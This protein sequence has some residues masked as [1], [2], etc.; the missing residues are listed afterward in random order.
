MDA[1]P[2]IKHIE[3]RILEA[4]L[5]KARERFLIINA[6]PQT[7]KSSYVGALLPFWL[8]G[9]MP[10]L[11][12]MY[13]SY[14]DDFSES[15]SKDVRA[16]QK[17]W[18]KELFGTSIDPDH[19]KVAEWRILGHR[20]GMLSVGIGGLITGKPG[21]C[22]P[23]DTLVSTPQGPRRMDWLARNGGTVWGYDH[24]AGTAVPR[25]IVASAAKGKRPLVEVI[26]TS[27][28]R[29]RC[30]A[31]HPIYVVGKGYTPAR[32]VEGG[33]EVRAH[34]V[35]PCSQCGTPVPMRGYE[36][37][38]KMRT[39]SQAIFC[40]KPCFATSMRS[41]ACVR[42]GALALRGRKFCSRACQ[43]AANAESLPTATCPTCAAT[44]RPR[45]SRQRFC[46]RGCANIAHS[47][48]MIGA[49]NSHFK[50]GTSY[51][52]LF[53]EMRP[54]V[55]GRDG[56]SCV[57]CQSTV[58]LV[59]H[60]VDHNPLNNDPTNLIALCNSCHMRHHKS[61]PTPFPWFAQYAAAA[62]R[63]MTSRWRARTT[64]LQAKFSSTTAFS[65]T[66]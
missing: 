21:D 10:D 25:R 1:F 26:F 39:A 55:L 42:C 18:G 65:S 22:F 30:T 57:V 23:G 52:K 16:L 37:A 35:A 38:K 17:A 45:S 33:A 24:D 27:G 7:G 9:M 31:D 32:L 66:T 64:S 56:E 2:W 28:R 11:N 15:R 14:S 36:Y 58:R 54:L 19:N 12:L 44:F 20:G 60:H 50:D 59:V 6:P 46:S 13:I 49:G 4:I 41:H 5:D 8:T 47:V 3:Q 53:Q 34:R 40:G 43:V 51:S 62:S 63:S 48:R 29:L 61:I